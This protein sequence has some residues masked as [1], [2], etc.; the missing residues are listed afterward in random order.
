MKAGKAEY[1]LERVLGF[2][3]ASLAKT[4]QA[5]TPEEVEAYLIKKRLASKERAADLAR[6]YAESGPRMAVFHQKAVKLVRRIR[7]RRKASDP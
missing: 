5:P 2:M 3:D 4:G 6:Q 1:Q 7:Q